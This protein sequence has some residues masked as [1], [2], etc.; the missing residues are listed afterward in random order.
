[1]KVV[2]L[3]HY[4]LNLIY[5]LLISKKTVVKQNKLMNDPVTKLGKMNLKEKHI[6]L[7]GN[8]F[9][10]CKFYAVKLLHYVASYGTLSCLCVI[11]FQANQQ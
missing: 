9:T 5:K 7:V 11:K 4:H 8:T 10:N 6:K 3:T 1:M 2:I